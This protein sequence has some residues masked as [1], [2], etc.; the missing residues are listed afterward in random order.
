MRGLLSDIRS[1]AYEC[2][3]FASATRGLCCDERSL[4]RHLD[5]DTP[6]IPSPIDLRR[7]F[8]GGCMCVCVCSLCL[9][10]WMHVCVGDSSTGLQ[11]KDIV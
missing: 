5:F 1:H 4:M 9:H 2:V 11:S 6:K 3:A 10:S 8:D 7:P